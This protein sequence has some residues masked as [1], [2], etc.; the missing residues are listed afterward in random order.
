MK[1]RAFFLAALL[2]ACAHREDPDTFG[3][4]TD[5]VELCGKPFTTFTVDG[6]EY[7]CTRSADDTWTI[8]E[9][10]TP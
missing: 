10:P 6:R 4:S 2:G 8:E 3:W 5:L 7:G 9:E 1:L